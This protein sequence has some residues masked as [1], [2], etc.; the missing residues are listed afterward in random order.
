[1]VARLL[2]AR[3]ERC[4]SVSR[5]LPR[6]GKVRDFSLQRLDLANQSIDLLH[7]SFVRGASRNRW[8][9]RLNFRA[10][11]SIGVDPRPSEGGDDSRAERRADDSRKPQ[12]PAAL[13]AQHSH[14][15]ASELFVER[16][17]P[18]HLR[19]N[20]S[21]LSHHRSRRPAFRHHPL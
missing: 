20:R 16:V 13:S 12:F 8:Q 18:R 1:M 7:G 11:P 17:K 6:L 5:L 4:D 19:Y 9:Q 21:A 3:F 10:E 14:R 2:L 15:L